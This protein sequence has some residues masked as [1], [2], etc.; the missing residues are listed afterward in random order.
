MSVEILGPVIVALW[1]GAMIWRFWPWVEQIQREQ[2]EDPF[3]SKRWHL[4]AV[5]FLGLL[6]IVSIILL[7]FVEDPR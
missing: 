3:G 6:M 7:R 1:L 2:R 5:V 4:P